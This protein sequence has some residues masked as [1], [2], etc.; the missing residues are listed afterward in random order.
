MR[1]A[2][3]LLVMT[4][5]GGCAHHN[6]TPALVAGTAITAYG[7]VMLVGEDCDSA[8][9]DGQLAC[10]YGRLFVSGIALVGVVLLLAGL[11]ADDPPVPAIVAPPGGPASPRARQVRLGFD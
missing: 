7:A 9:A 1:I 5:I 11:A 10:G 6:R 8:P 2:T 4:L 3:A